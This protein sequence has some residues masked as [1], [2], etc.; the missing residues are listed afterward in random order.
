MTRRRS[1]APK[2]LSEGVMVDYH[3]VIDEPATQ[4][5]MRVRVGPQLLSSGH[6]VVWL[7]GKAGCVHV[8]AVTPADSEVEHSDGAP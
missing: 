6:W 1:A 4:R 7:E 2:W 8:D 3:S 5:N